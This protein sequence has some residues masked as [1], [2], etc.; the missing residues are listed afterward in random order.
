MEL[1]LIT[2]LAWGA[3]TATALLPGILWAKVTH[4]RA[5]ARG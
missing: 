1:L 2:L 5:D 3:F 4:R